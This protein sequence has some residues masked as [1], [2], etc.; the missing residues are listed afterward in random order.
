MKTV[1]TLLIS[2]IFVS[3]TVSAQDWPQFRGPGRDGKVVGFAAPS[4]WPAELTLNWKAQVGTGDASPV[5]SGSRL[6]IHTRMADDEL[7]YCLDASSGRELWKTTYPAP[8]VTGPSASHP[9]PRT[10]PSISEGRIVTI[11][12]TGIITCLDIN[13]GKIVWQKDNP[14]ITVPQFFT[15]MS[16]LVSDG[17]CIVH[18]GTRE[19]GSIVALDLATGSEKWKVNGDG[20]SYSSPSLMVSGGQKHIVITTEKNLMGINFTDG[21]VLWQVPAPVQ[22]RFYNCTSPVINGQVIYYTGQGTG[23]K[24][25][26]VIKEGNSY[27]TRELWSNT[28][29]GAKWTTPVLKDGHLYGFTDQRRLYCINASDG[30]TAWIHPDVSSDFA[31]I[32]D[33]GSVLA[34]FPST[35]N[36][37]IFRPD[38]KAY[39]ELAK[40]KVSETVYTFPVFSGSSVYIKDAES[41]MMYSFK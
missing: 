23:T 20:P 31:T 22:Q 34:G 21:S 35:G 30:K 3:S 7:V 25:I 41:I 24:A 14:A 36:L 39:N 9:G 28:E 40:Y 32:V 10:T 33:C 26:E 19:K 11:G 17:T 15:G 27:K 1:M 12:V 4:K 37:M 6:F 2:A 8:P 16:P 29:A 13:T 38:P 18:T 5:L